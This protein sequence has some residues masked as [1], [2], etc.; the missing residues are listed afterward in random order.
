MSSNNPQEVDIV[1][2]GVTI[3]ASKVASTAQVSRT[4]TYRKED[5][6]ALSAEKKH[7]L[8]SK[9][10]KAKQQTEYQL[11][12]PS[13]QDLDDL[14][15][16]YQ[17]HMMLR[18]T[19]INFITYDLVDVFKIVYPIRDP[20]TKELTGGLTMVPKGS[21]VEAKCSDL[22]TEYNQLTLE[23]VADSSEWY[24]RFCRTSH[25]PWIAENFALSADYLRNHIDT[26]FLGKID[27]TLDAYKNSP[28][29][30]GPLIFSA[31]MHLL[32][33]NTVE[34]VEAYQKRLKNFK[35]TDYPGENVSD[36]VS[37]MRALIDV[38]KSLRVYDSNGTLIR[39]TIPQDLAKDLLLIFQTSSTTQF[40]QIFQQEYNRRRIEA[41]TTTRSGDVTYGDPSDTL[42]LALNLYGEMKHKSD[43]LGTDAK[44]AAFNAA[45][46]RDNKGNKSGPPAVCHNCKGPHQLR[47][48]PKP[49]DEKEIQKNRKAFFEKKRQKGKKG[50][51]NNK[52][53]G[54]NGGNKKKS[55]PDWTDP[56]WPPRPAKGEK[57][58]R[59]IRGVEHYYH[60]KD[61]LWKLKNQATPAAAVPASSSTPQT[62]GSSITSGGTNTRQVVQNVVN[63]L[64]SALQNAL[65]QSLQNVE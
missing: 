44:G 38:L 11:L 41:M 16:T 1:I 43:W 28:G 24:Q 34:V 22:F 39:E 23:Q 47:D 31:M 53:G 33:Q 13:I 19:Q 58:L 60:F 14:D 9:I 15:E 49:H 45:G 61:G 35:I 50:G 8:F 56:G 55:L 57:N 18:Q 6:A 63:N 21:T 30:G 62:P 51:A 52:G 64:Q 46:G 17:L 3:K 25:T 5:R 48:C 32:Q 36:M 40:N 12:E 42:K 65:T 29:Y 7:D 26:K 27:E 10:T 20:V 37:H 54:G 4:A 2:D 59:K